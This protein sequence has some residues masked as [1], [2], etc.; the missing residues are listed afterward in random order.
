MKPQSTQRKFRVSPLTGLPVEPVPIWDWSA[1]MLEQWSVAS[2]RFGIRIA[3][4]AAE[5]VLNI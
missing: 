1:G 2:S 3:G 5:S 4:Y